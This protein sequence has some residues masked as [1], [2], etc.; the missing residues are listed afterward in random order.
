MP[1]FF[2]IDYKNIISHIQN[3]NRVEGE[4]L[5]VDKPYALT[6]FEVVNKIKIAIKKTHPEKLKVGHA[7][8]LDPLA[9]GLLIVC[10][11]KK[12][13]QIESFQAQEKEYTGTFFIGATTPCYDKEKEV[14]AV[15]P[16]E[17]IT[18]K[19]IHQVANG[20]EG[21]Q[22]Q[23]PPVYSAVHV[24]GKR[25]YDL[26]REG[27]EQIDIASKKIEIKKFEITRIAL[28][29]VDF[30][31]VCSKGTYIRALARDF[32]AALGSGAYLA[33]LRRTRIGS[34]TVQ[35][36]FSFPVFTPKKK[37]EKENV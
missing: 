11:G 36:A 8:T 15:F 5:L 1:I 2:K 25:A 21:V 19:E 23:T 24:A 13:K 32:G 4:V 9:T 27:V 17:H 6:S 18:E 12:T 34:F 29:E 26:A 30:K 16:T 22:M 31:V 14:D 28:P 37:T 20:F 3:I 35:E 10:V 7:G 33:A